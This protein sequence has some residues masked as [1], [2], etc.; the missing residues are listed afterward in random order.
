[1]FPSI[2]LNDPTSCQCRFIPKTVDAQFD[3]CLIFAVR[4]FSAP[5]SPDRD[6]Q[7][8]RAIRS[9][10]AIRQEDGRFDLVSMFR[11][12]PTAPRFV[13][14]PRPPHLSPST[15]MPPPTRPSRPVAAM[16]GRR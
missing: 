5:Y 6:C 7:L 16:P 10:L 9:R 1:M 13:K 2:A 4:V 12:V 11:K 14:R 8:R 15:W 3:R